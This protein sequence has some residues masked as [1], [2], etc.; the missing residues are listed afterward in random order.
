MAGMR[1]AV[2]AVLGTAA[3]SLLAPAGAQAGTYDVV[4]CRAPGAD[5]V[6]RAWTVGYGAY[7][8][9]SL[10]EPTK[11]D[12]VQEC[13]GARTFLLARSTAQDGIEAGWARSAF[14][15][16]D[17]PPSSV[18]SKI[19]L[20]RH[21]QS[22]RAD[23]AD[24]GGDEWDVFA[25]TDDGTLS[26]EGCVVP[27]GQ[28]NC[29]VGAPEALNRKDVSTASLV[30]YNLDT[31][32]ALWGVTCNP[33]TLKNCPT[34]NALGYP[35]GSFNLWGSVVTIRDDMKPALAV[36][37]ALWAEGWRRPGDALV[38]N[39][40]DNAGIRTVRAQVGS[41][42]A[43]AS[44]SCDYHRPAPCVGQLSGSLAL[45][46]AP[47][48]G[49]QPASVT[50][51]DAAGNETT[52]TRTVHIDGN[53]PTVDLRPPR[54][55]KIIVSAKDHASGFAAGQIAVR[56]S[57]TEPHRALPTIYR[58]G[59]LRARLDR[60]NPRDVDVVVTVRDNA[61]N[62]ITGAPARFR[63]TSVTSQR[64]RAKVR[65][66]GRVRVKF[67]RAVTIRGQLVLSG[68]RPVAGVPITVVTRPRV[69]GAG[70]AVEATGTVGANGRFAITLPK[71]PARDA[72]ITYPGGSGFIPAERRLRLMVPAS[73]T[74]RASRLRL[75]GAGL[76]RFRGRVR[77]GAGANLVVV[78]QGKE[79][80]RWRTFV[81]TR[82]RN[83][84]RWRASYRF[85]GLPGAYPIRARIRRQGG[86][87]Y[88][89]GV[90]KRVTV[91]VG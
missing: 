83:G 67:G 27:D 35:Y 85:S 48:D 88:E 57:S 78:L 30:T 2:R 47:P 31:A 79:R 60:G 21:G 11:F 1:I 33:S 58:G 26:L 36:G 90:S 23:S 8:S 5:G 84:G 19:Q 49:P 17:A 32:W 80:G 18:I 65:E 61:G 64:L 87:P 15:R 25:Q 53:A 66:G 56:N 28:A 75:D 10:A 7:P 86:L 43:A 24:G 72:S 42:T 14:L 54:R 20:W 70:S 63:I 16:F 22:V 38:Y 4:S 76:V 91:H 46:A 52:T 12:V 44:G 89:T 74:I 82:T 68:R 45:A 62:E 77:G 40:S 41:V 81:D 3:L 39:T 51:I 34:A 71:G 73:S 55:R 37:G 6:N 69:R 50:A 13:P 29:N 59:K 9:H